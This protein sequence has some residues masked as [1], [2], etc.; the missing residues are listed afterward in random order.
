MEGKMF[1]PNPD[2]T[3]QRKVTFQVPNERGTFDSATLRCDFRAMPADQVRKMRED[4]ADEGERFED[5]D[6]LAH[7]L[8]GV[9]GVGKP[10]GSGEPLDPEDAVEPMLD[11]ASFVYE[12]SLEY[13]NAVLGGNLKPK[14]SGKQPATGSR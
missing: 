5:R 4:A 14:T 2:R 13:Y 8:V 1:T 7:A 12:A 3:F 6:M 10:D 9:H 11:E